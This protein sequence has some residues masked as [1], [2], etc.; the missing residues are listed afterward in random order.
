MIIIVIWGYVVIFQ[1]IS[2]AAKY[3]FKFHDF[4]GH[5]NPGVDFHAED[6]QQPPHLTDG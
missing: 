5:T 4:H 3:I 6:K 1:N 2:S